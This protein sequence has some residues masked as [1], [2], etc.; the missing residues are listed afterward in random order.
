MICYG[1]IWMDH[2]ERPDDY[3]VSNF[4]R[5]FS[6]KSCMMLKQ[7]LTKAGYLTYGSRLGSVHRLIVT[8]YLGPIPKGMV[9]N[10]KNGI[11]TDNWIDNLEITTHSANTQHAYDTG[12]AK[13][14]KG[15]ANSQAKVT[16]EIILDIYKMFEAGFS[17]QDIS[18]R[19]GLHDRYVSLIRHGKRWKYLYVRYGKTFPRSYEF[20][21]RKEQILMARE[22]L[23]KGHNNLTIAMATGIEK[24]NISRFRHGKMNAWCEWMAIYDRA[25]A[26][27]IESLT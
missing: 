9:V 1:E 16:E 23:L 10:H 24:S 7:S 17:N 27:T 19:Y 2:K 13:G 18:K 21:F 4:G 26:T 12:L 8:H 3:I 15:A 5:V 22:L 25:T 11:K 14:K 20:V 6:R